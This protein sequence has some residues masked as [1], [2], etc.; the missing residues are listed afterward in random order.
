M[1]LVYRQNNIIAKTC[2]SVLYDLNY[3]VSTNTF[4]HCRESFGTSQP[5][6]GS[7]TMYPGINL[8]YRQK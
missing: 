8:I 3:K 5:K 7:F 4:I 1:K 2:H 6:E